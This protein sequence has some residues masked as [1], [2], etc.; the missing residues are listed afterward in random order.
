MERLADAR[1]GTLSG[2]E[3]QRVAL[4]RALARRPDVLLLDEPLSALDSRTRASAA[5]ELGAVLREVEVPAL[6]VTHDFPEAALLGDRVG[7][8]DAGRVVQ[9]G[10]A[11]RA[12][13]GST[14]VVRGGLH[15]RRGA[16]RQRDPGSGRP[17]AR[18]ARRRRLGDEHR[19]GS[20]RRGGQRLPLGDRGAPARP[21]GAQ[22]ARRR[23]ASRPRSRRSPSSATVCAWVWRRDSRS[24]PRSR[25]PPRTGWSCAR[26]RAWSPPGRRPPPG[27]WPA[28]PSRAGRAS[29]ARR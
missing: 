24:R 1:P 14:H 10:S 13:G 2:G 21:G 9:E 12:G 22:R 16:H 29:A 25:S 26:A 11:G 6:L 19:R 5:R 15:R 3:R 8:I 17:H 18:G 7:V 23:T 27:S 28:R 4:A 20:R